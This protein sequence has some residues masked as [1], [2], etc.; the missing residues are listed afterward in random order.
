LINE[1]SEKTRKK[2]IE[3][4]G[5]DIMEIDIHFLGGDI[6]DKKDYTAEI[7]SV[8]LDRLIYSNFGC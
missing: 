5:L 4:I 3:L 1:L 2:E 8:I 6:E 7:T